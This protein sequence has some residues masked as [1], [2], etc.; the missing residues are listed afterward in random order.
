MI[1]I[2]QNFK[3]A[4]NIVKLTFL[5]KVLKAIVVPAGFIDMVNI[6]FKGAK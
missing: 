1:L 6:L 4:Y 2:K 5:S 3:K